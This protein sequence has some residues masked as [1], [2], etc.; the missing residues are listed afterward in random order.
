MAVDY[1]NNGCV[2]HR[3]RHCQVF[4]IDFLIFLLKEPR[5]KS[6]EP[7]KVQIRK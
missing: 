4:E 1:Y 5:T 7:N 6:Q 3:C 2:A